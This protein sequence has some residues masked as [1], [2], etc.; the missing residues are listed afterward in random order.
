MAYAELKLKHQDAKLLN[1]YQRPKYDPHT[2]LAWI[3]DGTAGVAHSAHPNV[4]ANRYTRAKYPGW[5]ECRGFLHSP[6]VFV[7]T[8]LDRIAAAY[9]H[10]GPCDEARKAGR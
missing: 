3:E 8:E 2:G 10:C 7:S 9:C 4:E 5:L 1:E 6:E